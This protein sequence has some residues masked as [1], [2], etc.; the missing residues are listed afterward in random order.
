MNVNKEY[1]P[2][3]YV[4]AKKDGSAAMPKAKKGSTL[5]TILAILGILVFIGGTASVLLVTRKQDTTPVAPSAPQS[6]P[7]AYI[8]KHE[9]CTISFDVTAPEKLSCGENG[10]TVDSDCGTGLICLSTSD[11][12]D[13]NNPIKYC[14]KEDYED[15][16]VADPSVSSCCTEPEKIACGISSCETNSDCE[17]DLICVTTEAVDSEGLNIKF[18]SQEDYKDNCIDDPSEASCCE[19]PEETPT[20]TIT[21]TVTT[22]TTATATPTQE[23]TT[24]ITTVGC[25]ESCNENADCSNISH[26]C[27]EGACRLD[28]NPEDEQCL[29]ANGESTIVRPV[30]VQTESGP[31]EWMQYLKAG[32]GTLGIGALLLL[33]L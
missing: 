14:A 19:E 26:I 32:L 15:A 12:D 17:D 31:E 21:T 2:A 5:K 11:L 1:Q 30:V 6:K 16:C 3:K 9:T 23:V 10:C 22:T 27:Y 25:N 4:K 20:E 28:V 29:L 8:E 13:D 18:C 33:L 24:V 7:A